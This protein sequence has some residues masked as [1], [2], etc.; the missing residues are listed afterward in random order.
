M[1]GINKQLRD[2]VRKGYKLE[3]AAAACGLDMD[4]ASMALESMGGCERKVTISELIENFKPKAAEILME[5]AEN[6]E[7]DSDRVKACQ[8]LLTGEGVMPE[9]NALDITGKMILFNQALARANGQ[10]AK[11]IEAEVV[12]S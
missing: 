9:V 5:I 11:V 1:A 8:I 12:N 6:G 2:M 4:V 10:A 7:K 3:D